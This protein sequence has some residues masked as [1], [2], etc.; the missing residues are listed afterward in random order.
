MV[1]EALNQEMILT[2][3]NAKTAN[4]VFEQLGGTM[5]QQGYCKESFVQALMDR[6]TAAPTGIN[7]RGVGVAVPHTTP[8]HV[9]REGLAIG[10]LRQ[11][12][13][14]LQM[15]TDDIDVPVQ[16]VFMMAITDPEVHMPLMMRIFQIVQDQAVLE[17][18]LQ[19]KSKE[20]IAEIIRRKEA[21]IDANGEE[22]DDS[23][24][25]L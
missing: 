24:L 22:F 10:Q 3:L 15:G 20:E 2:D 11:P 7:M 8:E 18:L 14:F 19:A 23:D 12:V 21:S 25:D 16:L 6:E 4:E 5:V 9:N 13:H 1:F 17:K